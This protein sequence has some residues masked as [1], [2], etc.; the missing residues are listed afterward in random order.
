[1]DHQRPRVVFSRCLGFDHCRY[2]SGIISEPMVGQLKPFVDIVTVCPE[3]EI[4]VGTPRHP[5][6]L[7]GDE[8][9]S[10]LVQPEARLPVTEK[11]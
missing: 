2:N 11:M 7:L 4:G 6:R 8:V 5:I 10:R 3:V 1:M 9:S